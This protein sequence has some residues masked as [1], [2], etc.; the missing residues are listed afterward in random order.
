MRADWDDAPGW[1]YFLDYLLPYLKL[2]LLIGSAIFSLQLIRVMPDVR[3]MI[4]PTAIFCGGL[5]IYELLGEI[6]DRT[7]T[8]NFSLGGEPLPTVAYVGKLFML[9]LIIVSPPFMVWWY[10]RQKVLSRYTLNTFLQP[11]V[12]C[13]CGFGSLWILMDLIDIMKDLQEAHVPA[14]TVAKLYVS[15][16][17][18]IYVTVTP[19]AFLL[20]VLYSLTRMSRSNEIV[21]MLTAGV[22]LEQ[23]LKPMMVVVAYAS[24]IGMAANYYWAPYGQGGRNALLRSSSEKQSGTTAAAG[25]M[26]RNDQTAR[27]WFVGRVPFDL[28]TEKMRDVEVRETLPNGR[29]VHGWYASAGRWWAKAKM[30]SLYNGVEVIYEHGVAKKVIPFEES[31]KGTRI[32]IT[33]WPETPW[34]IMSTSMLPDYLTVPQLIGY[35][36]SN[37]TTEEAKLRAFS[38]QLN[39]RFSLPWQCFVIALAAAPLGVAFSRRG[40]LGGVAAAVGSFFGLMFLDNFFTSL[41]KGGRMPVWLAVW[42]PHLILCVLGLYILKLKSG[43]REMRLPKVA[44]L[45]AGAKDGWAMLTA[46][47]RTLRARFG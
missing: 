22:S 7:E 25:L 18:F 13:I 9:A 46:G 41:A 11:L 16:L 4:L 12:F 17:P 20:A 38:V 37:S 3:S 43:N 35:L 23:I 24:L 31:G 33:G 42:M 36:G 1:I 32:D 40:G 26:Y 19:A 45:V 30:W 47:W 10:S 44:E 5:C 29:L 21:A 14:R 34:N 8:I 6:A 2:C 15:L 39:H 27:T 28:R